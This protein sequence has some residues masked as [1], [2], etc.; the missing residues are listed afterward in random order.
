MASTPARNVTLTEGDYSKPELLARELENKFNQNMVLESSTGSQDPTTGTSHSITTKKQGG[1]VVGYSFARYTQKPSFATYQA[2]NLDNVK[3][4]GQQGQVK[5]LEKISKTSAW[6]AYAECDQLLSRGSGL[7]QFQVAK[8]TKG[9]KTNCSFNVLAAPIPPRTGPKKYHP[10]NVGL[11]GGVLVFLEGLPYLYFS[12]AK[13]GGISINSIPAG[14]PG[15]TLQARRESGIVTWFYKPETKGA[16]FIPIA[17][18]AEE[19]T[20]GFGANAE[21]LRV[22]AALYTVPDG[23]AIISVSP[24][25]K[26]NMP[27]VQGI[28]RDINPLHVT[29]FAAA[30]E[31]MSTDD[32]S[33]YEVEGLVG[34]DQ[35]TIATYGFGPLHHQL[36][37]HQASIATAN[38]AAT[39]LN[40]SQPIKGTGVV[41]IIRIDSDLPLHTRQAVSR[42]TTNTLAM[43]LRPE[44]VQGRIVF[45]DP[46]PLPLALK[47]SSPTSISSLEVALLDDQGQELDIEGD[48]VIVL[49]IK[50]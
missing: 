28:E 3:A 49:A 1:I 36:G 23:I 21:P 37:M 48:C 47:Y 34:N 43:V 32:E 40:S 30:D 45:N 46:A 12:P 11:A 20:Y 16:Q 4:T 5:N 15:D 6:D 27:A 10:N 19:A 25:I 2:N 38:S 22:S 44:L 41:P 31:A 35:P 13:P 9:G 14:Q 26:H 17:E 50:E 29:E 42:K 18:T 24:D 8:S 33:L 39:R 7:A